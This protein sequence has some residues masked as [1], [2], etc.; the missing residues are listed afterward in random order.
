MLH[1]YNAEY[2]V[3]I[4]MKAI[5]DQVTFIEIMEECREPAGRFE[6]WKR[7]VH[8]NTKIVFSKSLKL[9]QKL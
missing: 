1:K 9:S 3:Q 2:E 6:E 4:T 8:F 5:M 7:Y